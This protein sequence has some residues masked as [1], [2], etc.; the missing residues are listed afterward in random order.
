MRHVIL[1]VFFGIFCGFVSFI[2]IDMFMRTGTLWGLVV[3]TLGF[4]AAFNFTMTATI[5]L[6]F[7]RTRNSPF[8]TNSHVLMGWAVVT[9]FGVYLIVLPALRGD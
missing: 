5:P 4:L 3:L 9:L 6:G 2:G 7:I 8:V 1:A